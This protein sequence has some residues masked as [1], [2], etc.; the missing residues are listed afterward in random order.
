MAALMGAS[1][2]GQ[3]A[4]SVRASVVKAHSSAAAKTN[5]PETPISLKLYKELFGSFGFLESPK[6]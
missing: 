6:S 5:F 2:Y 4:G 3:F 1:G